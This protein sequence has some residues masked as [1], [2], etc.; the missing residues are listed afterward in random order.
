MGATYRES[1]EGRGEP[2]TVE[3]LRKRGYHIQLQVGAPEK[4]AKPA[5]P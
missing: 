5:T 2:G 1:G 3:R 4:I